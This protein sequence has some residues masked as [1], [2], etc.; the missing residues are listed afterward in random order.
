[1][2]NQNLNLYKY[3]GFGCF[4]S[5]VGTM[6]T[7][8]VGILNDGAAFTALPTYSTGEALRLVSSSVEDGGSGG[9]TGALTVQVIYLD[10]DG[11]VDSQVVTMNGTTNVNLTDTTVARVLDIHCLTFGSA[12]TNVGTITIQTTGGVNRMSIPA[13]HNR[14]APGRFTIPTGYA[15][16]YR[17]FNISNSAATNLVSV[18]YV[19]EADVNPLTGALNENVFQP[20]DWA[21]SGPASGPVGDRAPFPQG[22]RRIYLPEKCTVRARAVAV[23]SAS[24]IAA[25]F[26]LL[27]LHPKPT[28]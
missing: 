20:I 7:A 13:G 2:A 15:G 11:S 25:G 3:N 12:L 22:G 5:A 27:E 9:D 23:G 18:T 1:M 26:V 17:G 24:S 8:G 10:T 4:H 21:V 6:V 19:I 28:T 16:L 14:A